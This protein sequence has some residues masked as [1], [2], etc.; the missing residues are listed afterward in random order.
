MTYEEPRHPI[1]FVAHRTGL[2]THVIRVW[3]RRYSAIQPQRT[4][5]NRRLYSDADVDRLKL[6]NQVK[7]QGQSIRLIAQLPNQELKKML[8]QV[9][10]DKLAASPALDTRRA[11]DQDQVAALM[12]TCKD[13]VLNMNEEVLART[14][15]DASVQLPL[16]TLL[17]DLVG[18]LMSWVGARWHDGSIRVAH[19]H[20]A[21][22]AI[23]SFLGRMK[24][25][26]RA[27]VGAPCIVISTPAGQDHE[28]GALM[29]ATIAANEGWRDLY[30]GPNLP[31][32]EIALAAMEANAVAVAVSIVAPGNNPSV[33]HEF[34]TLR[35][36]LQER[37]PMLAGGGGIVQNRHH[38]E[39][40]GVYCVDNLAQFRDRL[41]ALNR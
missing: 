3:E 38:Y 9:D 12:S 28:I 21:T 29:A 14:L 37:I 11:G 20:M 2:S 17:D 15:L 5:T 10:G 33:I 39:L 16:L 27:G 34:H 40:D 31:A 22:A 25:I 18:P 4:D 24:Q 30:L 41:V 8:T 7:A 13:A 6:L 23:R 35:H 19:E 1:N 36:V 26:R 32:Q